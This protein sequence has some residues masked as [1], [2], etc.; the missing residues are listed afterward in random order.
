MTLVQKF[1]K[2][3]LVINNLPK[4]SSYAPSNSEKLIFYSNY[5]QATEGP[6]NTKRPGMLDFVGKSKWDTWDGLKDISKDKAMQNYIDALISVMDKIPDSD[7]KK[8]FLACE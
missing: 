8:S 7:Y 4:D 5:K 6:C 2:A 1:D 3:V